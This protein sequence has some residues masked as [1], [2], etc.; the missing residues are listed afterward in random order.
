MGTLY[1]RVLSRLVT[2]NRWGKE[3]ELSHRPKAFASLRVPPTPMSTASHLGSCAKPF[4]TAVWLCTPHSHLERKVS[5][6][7][8][9]T[10]FWPRSCSAGPPPS[11]HPR[12][13]PQ[14]APAAGSCHSLLS[15]QIPAV[16]PG[17]QTAVIGKH[18][19]GLLHPVGTWAH[20]HVL[21]A[22]KP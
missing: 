15:P 1:S 7:A 19:L 10:P 3:L 2:R 11:P 9:E 21:L 4:P 13:L 16:L 20:G 6:E 8:Q 12:A 17:V 18:P 22:V 14:E 5:Q